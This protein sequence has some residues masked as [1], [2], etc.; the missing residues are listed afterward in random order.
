MEEIKRNMECKWRNKTK[1]KEKFRSIYKQIELLSN[2]KNIHKSITYSR[3]KHIENEMLK[4]INC[5][6]ANQQNMYIY[7]YTTKYSQN[8]DSNKWWDILCLWIGKFN[9]QRC[10]VSP[11]PSKILV[12]FKLL[13]DCFIYLIL[14]NLTNWF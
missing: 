4:Q 5:L 11:V 14:E 6:G 9:V 3:K 10:Q 1:I 7:I 12:S 13:A 8:K 2:I